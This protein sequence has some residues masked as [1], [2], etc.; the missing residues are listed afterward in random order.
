[1]GIL[2]LTERPDNHVMWVNYAKGHTGFVV[3]FDA[4]S[5]FFEED[6]RYLRKVIYQPQAP[7]YDDADENGCFY[8]SLD[9]IKEDEWRCIRRFKADERRSVSFEWLMIKEIIFGSQMEPW[10][11]SRIVQFATTYSESDS[12]PMPLLFSSTLVELEA[13]PPD[14]RDLPRLCHPRQL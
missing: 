14:L 8:K 2:C 4:K 12:V 3:G 13:P 11:I 5:S 6:D 1:M 9:W 7:L 10:M